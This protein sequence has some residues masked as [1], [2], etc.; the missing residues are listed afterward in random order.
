[1]NIVLW[2]NSYEKSPENDFEAVVI[3]PFLTIIQIT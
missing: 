1:M 3:S 2:S